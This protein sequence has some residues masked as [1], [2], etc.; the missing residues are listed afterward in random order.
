VK[1][2]CHIVGLSCEGFEDE[3]VALFIAIEAS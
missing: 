2:F 3:L 1:S